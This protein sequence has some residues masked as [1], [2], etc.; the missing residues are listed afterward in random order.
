MRAGR[1]L[2][3]FLSES[4]GGM[5][6]LREAVLLR[7]VEALIAAGPDPLPDRIEHICI[8]LIHARSFL[9]QVPCLVR[10]VTGRWF[11]LGN[12]E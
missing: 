7:S 3:K 4:L 1:V 2:Q 12:A 11:D 9:V 5:H 6:A 8:G 10:T